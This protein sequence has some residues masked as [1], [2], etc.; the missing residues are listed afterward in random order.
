MNF[1]NNVES[2]KSDDK[3]NINHLLKIAYLFNCNI[4]DFF[5]KNYSIEDETNSA[6]LIQQKEFIL[7]NKKKRARMQENIKKFKELFLR[8]KKLGFIKSHRSNNTGIGKTFEDICGII[9]N[10]FDAA[11]FEG[12]EIKSHRAMSN[13]YITLFTKSPTYPVKNT[14]V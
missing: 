11:D 5:P 7:R 1:V 8:S 13:S 10:N 14:I 3:Y 4:C 2:D 9:E 6:D 12:I